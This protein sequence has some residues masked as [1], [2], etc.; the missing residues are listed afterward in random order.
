MLFNTKSLR[1]K[2]NVSN[3]ALNLKHFDLSLN[4]TA[5]SEINILEFGLVLV[6][7]EDPL[8][9]LFTTITKQ[10]Y[11]IIG[12]YK[13]YSTDTEI[14]LVHIF[15]GYKPSWMTKS[16][17]ELEDL[18]C[19]KEIILFETE[20]FIE[21]FQECETM[22]I[23]EKLLITFDDMYKLP[24]LK[25][26]SHLKEN[27]FCVKSLIL[28]HN[29]KTTT[30]IQPKG[31]VSINFTKEKKYIEKI[32]SIATDIIIENKNLINSKKLDSNTLEYIIEEKTK[33]EHMF[34]SFLDD[35]FETGTTD[36]LKLEKLINFLPNRQ[37]YKKIPDKLIVIDKTPTPEIKS[38]IL[39]L[40]TQ[41]SDIIKTIKVGDIPCIELNRTIQTINNMTNYYNMSNDNNNEPLEY[42]QSSSSG[43]ISISSNES[44]TVPLILKTGNSIYLTSRNFN[45]TLFNTEELIEILE[46]IDEMIIDDRFDYLRNKITS[47]I[48]ERNKK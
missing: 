43:L 38:Y 30:I 21:Y 10:E 40:K 20:N 17:S 12:T 19:V 28:T 22:S 1:K 46:R 35:L 5:K 27:I 45:L 16:L 7:S 8:S 34:L 37:K 23:K 14:D 6:R 41:I 42:I 48:A 24:T 36:K 3:T 15:D 18:D 31:H 44:S 2:K 11:S 33:T 25:P 32:I 47:E 13:K 9:I 26:L 39:D 29:I 4:D